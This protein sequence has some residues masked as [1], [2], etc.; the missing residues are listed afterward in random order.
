MTFAGGEGGDVG[1]GGLSGEGSRHASWG[2]DHEGGCTADFELRAKY[3][4]GRRTS[5][6]KLDVKSAFRDTDVDPAG[7]EALGYVI[8]GE[9]GRSGQER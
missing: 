6:Q 9:G 1:D 3:G 2:G 8:G 4:T 5:I 7:A